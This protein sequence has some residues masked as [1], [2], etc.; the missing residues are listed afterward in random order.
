MFCMVSQS[1]GRNGAQLVGHADESA[2]QNDDCRDER[3]GFSP[4]WR[5]GAGLWVFSPV[6]RRF[7]WLLARRAGVRR[8]FRMFVAFCG[9]SNPWHSAFANFGATSCVNSGQLGP[10]NAA[11]ISLSVICPA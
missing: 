5:P 9:K 8:S 1:G 7:V 4:R 6:E 10:E 11:T 2:G 3:H